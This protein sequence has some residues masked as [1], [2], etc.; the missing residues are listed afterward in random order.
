MILDHEDNLAQM[1]H[2]YANAGDLVVCLGAGTITSWAAAL[3]EQI[4][5]IAPQKKQESVL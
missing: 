1:I 2:E 5:Q 3:P 4:A